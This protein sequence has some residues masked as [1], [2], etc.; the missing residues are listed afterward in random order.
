MRTILGSTLAKIAVLCGHSGDVSAINAKMVKEKL[1]YMVLP[2]NETWRI[3]IIK[4]MMNILNS[5]SQGCDEKMREKWSSLESCLTARK[6][7]GQ[8][9]PAEEPELLLTSN[10]QTDPKEG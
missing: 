1:R 3:G 6:N 4:D 10:S 2:E 7:E 5:D 9:A 8:R